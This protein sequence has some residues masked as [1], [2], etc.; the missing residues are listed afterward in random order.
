MHLLYLNT[1]HLFMKNVHSSF[2]QISAG[3]G[4]HCYTKRRVRIRRVRQCSTD[5]RHLTAV[6]NATDYVF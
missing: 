4:H 1:C 5:V 3:N 2:Y 6:L